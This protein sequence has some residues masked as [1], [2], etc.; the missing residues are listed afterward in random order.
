MPGPGRPPGRSARNV[1]SGKRPPIRSPVKTGQRGR[2]RLVIQEH[3]SEEG[4]TSPHTNDSGDDTDDSIAYLSAN[5]Q[6]RL[7]TV[8]VNKE[9]MVLGPNDDIEEL[10]NLTPNETEEFNEFLETSDGASSFMFYIP[11]F[12]LRL[13]CSI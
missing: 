9:V 11:C 2:P 6:K 12:S 13:H 8:D 10:L 3:N 7:R 4:T 1:N 5:R